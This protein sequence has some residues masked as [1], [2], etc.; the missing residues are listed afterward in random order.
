MLPPGRLVQVQPGK[1]TKRPPKRRLGRRAGPK[2]VTVIRHGEAQ[3]NVS[4]AFLHKRNTCLTA[5][6]RRQA[7]NLRRLVSQLR[8]DIVVTSP[9]LRALQTTKA[10]GFKG[11]TVV[12]P[13]ARERVACDMHLCDLPVQGVPRQFQSFDWSPWRQQTE[14]AGGTEKYL[15][16]IRDF[17]L[18]SN[19]NIRSRAKKFTRYLESRPEGNIA[20]VSHG[21]FLMHLTSGSYMDNCEVRT[22]EVEGGKW[23][24]VQTPTRTAAE[25]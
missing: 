13:D 18:Q 25:V 15:S 21:A 23:R 24:P 16:A 14:A 9:I 6:G 3:H 19:A 17:D 10:M 22:Y 20:L 1:A 5:R 12:A 8:P 11:P 4:D 2:L 7:Q